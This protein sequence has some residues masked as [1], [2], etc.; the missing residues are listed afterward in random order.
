MMLVQ[1]KNLIC[2][3]SLFPILV[4]VRAR[5]ALEDSATKCREE[6]GKQPL[7][8]EFLGLGSYGRRVVFATV[9]DGE[10]KDKLSQL[11]G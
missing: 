6:F 7:S 8:L 10:Q 3:S 4:L 2:S 9:A 5:N 1:K 11:A